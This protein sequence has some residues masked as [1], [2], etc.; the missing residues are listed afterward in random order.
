MPQSWQLSASILIPL[1]SPARKRARAGGRRKPVH[2]RAIPIWTMTSAART[3]QTSCLTMRTVVAARLRELPRAPRAFRAEPRAWRGHASKATTPQVR[4]SRGRATQRAPRKMCA[5]VCPLARGLLRSM[6]SC[7]GISS[8]TCSTADAATIP[9]PRASNGL[10]VSAA[11]VTFTQIPLIVVPAR[12]A[13]RRPSQSAPLGSAMRSA[14]RV[15]KNAER[16]AFRRD[17]RCAATTAR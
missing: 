10:A 11:A 5:A 15:Y 16:R 7:A 12:N 8:R 9:V 14:R 2:A 4:V 17:S 3:A 1:P 13:A 6:N